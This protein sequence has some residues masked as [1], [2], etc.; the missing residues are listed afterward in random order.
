MALTKP[1]RIYSTYERE[2]LALVKA[3]SNFAVCLLYG[4]LTWRTDNAALRNLFRSDLKLSSR[5]S[6]WIL[7]LKPYRIKIQLI[8]GK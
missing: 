8:K 3:V 1:D 4:E 6:R 7:T 5:V 2:L